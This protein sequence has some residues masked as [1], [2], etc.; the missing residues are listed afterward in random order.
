MGAFFLPWFKKCYPRTWS[1]KGYDKERTAS[2]TIDRNI[3][4]RF[5]GHEIPIVKRIRNYDS[6]IKLKYYGK[7][8]SW[9]TWFIQRHS[10][11]FT[12]GWWCDDVSGYI[13]DDFTEER[14]T[15]YYLDLQNGIAA[16]RLTKTVITLDSGRPDQSLFIPRGASIPPDQQYFNW[17][18]FP[19]AVITKT[20]NVSEHIVHG[21]KVIEVSNFQQQ[22][23][24]WTQKMALDFSAG[25][26]PDI[27]HLTELA[28]YYQWQPYYLEGK[29]NETPD[30]Y[31][32]FEPEWL[33]HDAFDKVN[34]DI[35]F[36]F[37]S[38]FS[39]VNKAETRKDGIGELTA[40]DG[41]IDMTPR[42]SWVVDTLGNFFASQMTAAGGVFNKLTNG[43]PQVITTEPEKAVTFFPIAPV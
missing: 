25:F 15:L 36:Q 26:L 18:K 31:D 34:N 17:V 6:N 7:G 19:H 20:I 24:S 42:G 10:N 39:P 12:G 14:G 13:K 32:F 40:M 11:N 16:Y 37:Y 41:A 30:G 21:S 1:Q 9:E 33:P 2:H 23:S 27:A 29:A 8:D 22:N 38:A 35:L 28:D 3:V 43:D 4:F 5:N